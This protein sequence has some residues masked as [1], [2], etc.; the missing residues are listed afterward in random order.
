MNFAAQAVMSGTGDLIIAGGVQK[1]SQLP[2]L[3]VPVGSR[4]RARI[5]VGHMTRLDGALQAIMT[6]AVEIDGVAKPATVIESVIRYV[7]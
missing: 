2:I 1:L 3:C 5:S 7:A 4:V 6:T